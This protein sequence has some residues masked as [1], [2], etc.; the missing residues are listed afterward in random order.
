MDGPFARAASNL[1]VR[2]LCRVEEPAFLSMD[3]HLLPAARALGVTYASP[4]SRAAGV[5]GAMLATFSR[6]CYRRGSRGSLVGSVRLTRPIDDSN[7]SRASSS[8]SH[9][10]NFAADAQSTPSSASLAFLDSL[11]TTEARPE[12]RWAH[13]AT[14]VSCKVR[15]AMP[16]SSYSTILGSTVESFALDLL[17]ARQCSSDARH[18]HTG[19]GVPPSLPGVSIPP[20]SSALFFFFFFFSTTA[21]FCP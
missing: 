15:L 13:V 14:A 7:V 12:P 11:I 1:E 19:A 17:I 5:V 4:M 8:S 21:G 3:I 10:S 9:V 6:V 2:E 16:S 20:A 18:L